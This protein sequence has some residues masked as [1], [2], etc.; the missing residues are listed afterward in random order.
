M[1]L[2]CL[3]YKVTSFILKQPLGINKQIGYIR[4]YLY[5]LV[6]IIYV[7]LVKHNLYVIGY[8]KRNYIKRIIFNL[9]VKVCMRFPL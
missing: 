3:E 8:V 9:K 4:A 7:M 2:S 6:Y 1:W 5:R